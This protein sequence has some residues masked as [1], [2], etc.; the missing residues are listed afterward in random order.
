ML[1]ALQH[2]WKALPGFRH[3]VCEKCGCVKVWDAGW[4][5]LVYKHNYKLTLS[6]PS[7]YKPNTKNILK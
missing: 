2:K 3:H 1:K 6:L 7:C 5:R 4:Q